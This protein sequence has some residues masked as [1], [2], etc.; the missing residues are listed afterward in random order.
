MNRH[1]FPDTGKNTR[2]L[3]SNVR[4]REAC[5]WLYT[6]RREEQLM[7]LPRMEKL[8]RTILV[9]SSEWGCMWPEVPTSFPQLGSDTGKQQ[10]GSSRHHL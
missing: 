1:W 6:D 7:M 5:K 9:P 2:I 8:V 10:E 4:L 3:G